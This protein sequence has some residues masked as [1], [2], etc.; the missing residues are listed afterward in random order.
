MGVLTL[1]YAL[2]LYLM[3]ALLLLHTP[4]CSDVR[5]ADRSALPLGGLGA[6]SEYALHL[7]SQLFQSHRSFEQ[8]KALSALSL[9]IV[10][11]LRTILA[12]L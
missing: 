2:W 10:F 3:S 1:R 8:R 9:F 11:V 4:S 5:W 7:P 6:L 12:V